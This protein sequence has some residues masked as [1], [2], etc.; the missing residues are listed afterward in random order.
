MIRLMILFLNLFENCNSERALEDLFLQPLTMMTPCGG[1]E[2]GFNCQVE[3]REW[4]RA[5]A[6]QTAGVLLELT[7]AKSCQISFHSRALE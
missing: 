3:S 7:V 6:L 2:A 1:L 4:I 5:Q